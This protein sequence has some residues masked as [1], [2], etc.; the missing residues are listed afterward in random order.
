MTIGE[1]PRITRGQPI[2]I[3]TQ[4]KTIIIRMSIPNIDW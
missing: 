1:A 3:A 2:G 4:G